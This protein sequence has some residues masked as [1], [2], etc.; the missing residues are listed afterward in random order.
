[1][2]ENI[3][4]VVGAVV[5]IL[6]ALFFVF[7]KRRPDAP[8]KVVPPESATKPQGNLLDNRDEVEAP[9]EIHDGMTL[10]EVKRA[11]SAK[12]VGDKGRRET[13]VEA[14]QK[15]K[16]DHSETS[17]ASEVDDGWGAML[18]DA[19]PSEA[20]PAVAPA[21]A[22]TKKPAQGLEEKSESEVP[23][24]VGL[25]KTRSG[26]V[27]KLSQLFKGDELDANLVE[28]V[29]EILYT[30]DIGPK[31]AA[32]IIAAIESQLEGD[33]KKDPAKVWGFVRAHVEEKL[34]KHEKKIDFSA[35]QPFVI[36][37][38]GVNGAGKTT[39]IGKLAS[40][41]QKQGKR[42]LMV[43]GDTFRAA[44]VEQLGVWGERT[45]IPVHQGEADADPASVVFAGI[46]RGVAEG[47]DVIICDTAGR[48]HTNVN[49][50]E[51]LKKIRRVA[52]K[53]IDSAPHETFLVLDA[54]T[55][56]NAIQQA[57]L[58][59]EAVDVSG[60]VLTKL[61]GTA[62]AGRISW[63]CEELAAPIRYI[64]IGEGVADLREFHAKE[65]V[66]ALFM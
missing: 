43:A 33:D 3:W 9:V 4:L 39:T 31:A 65:F 50:L 1:M 19:P 30:A 13:A 5:L 38:V 48:L 22:A 16:L 63:I 14:T 20:D 12:V 35:H 52:S 37:V 55:G 7:G 64:G 29:E 51:E 17:E 66:D 26:F 53:V 47:A 32:D 36:L 24:S 8:P 46:E 15:S 23:L 62:K 61:D 6:V 59:S 44:A 54:N 18:D 49:L 11:K 60:I 58:F 34:S 27:G 28:E 41:F 56:Q 2:T 45:N 42:V 25:A 40:K 21:P 10:A 57:R